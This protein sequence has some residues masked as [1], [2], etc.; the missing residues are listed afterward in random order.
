MTQKTYD[1]LKFCGQVV[2][3][4]GVFISALAEIWGFQ[5][6]AE[7]AASIAAAAVLLNSIVRYS[8]EAYFST[9][10]IV[11]KAKDGD[12]DGEGEDEDAEDDEDGDSDGD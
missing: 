7:I 9:H 12:S 5:Y 8:S 1:L 4:V 11:D 6:G 2:G 3:Y 10:D